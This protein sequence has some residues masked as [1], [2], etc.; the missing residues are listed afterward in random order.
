MKQKTLR[1]RIAD[2]ERQVAQLSDAL[3]MMQ[4]P[5]PPLPVVLGQPIQIKLP[6]FPYAPPNPPP[7]QFPLTISY[8]PRGA[9]TG[10][11]PGIGHN[12]NIRIGG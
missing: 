3:A 2:L 7:Q 1:Q 12:Q 5:Y 6:P 11:A 10:C 4:R 8:E 9:I